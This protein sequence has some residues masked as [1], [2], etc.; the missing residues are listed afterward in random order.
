MKHLVIGLGEVGTALQSILKCEGWDV[1]TD[2]GKVVPQCDILHICF[3][4]VVSKD[5]YL[6]VNLYKT[7]T[8]AKYVVIHS[9]VPVGTSSNLGAIHS[10][11]RGVHPHLENSIR[12]FVKYFGGENAHVIATE[13]R[14]FGINCETTEKPETTEL[15]KLVDTSTYGVNILL[16]KEV[17]RL[18]DEYSVP[19]ETVYKDA[20][21][22]YNRGYNKLKMPQFQK[23]I[24]EHREGPI[25]GH[26]IMQNAELLDTWINRLLKNINPQL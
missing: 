13:F 20:N 6:D 16:Q 14:K 9:T 19:F 2:A 7:I 15:M 17:K 4:F 24:L 22:T 26:C 18:C 21:F 8:L 12:T 25:G 1:K 11:I 5:F 3:P 23:Y 10:P